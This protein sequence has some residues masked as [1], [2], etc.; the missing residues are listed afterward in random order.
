VALTLREYRPQDAEQLRGVFH[1]AVRAIGPEDYSAAQLAAW[2]PEL[3][4]RHEWQERMDL[5]SPFVLEEAGA[6]VGYADLQPSGYVDHFFVHPGWQRRGGGALLMQAIHR[7]AAALWL[8]RLFADV[9]LTARPFFET[10]GFSVI[11]EQVVG[12]RGAE[13]KNFR[14]EK[15]LPGGTAARPAR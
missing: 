10:W 9:S 8:A 4:L 11:R 3:W 1:A 14:M 7:K 13:L 12:V 2:A 15:A 5:R 6:I